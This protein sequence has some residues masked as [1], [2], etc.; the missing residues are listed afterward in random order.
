MVGHELTIEH[1]EPRALHA[2]DQPGER[3][4]ARILHAAEHALP[5]KHPVEGDSIEP[6][7]EALVPGLVGLPAFE[8]VRVAHTLERAIARFDAVA[9]PAFGEGF[10]RFGAGGDRGGEIPVAGD[11]ESILPDGLA[12]ALGNVE[13]VKREDRPFARLHPEHLGIVPVIGHWKQTGAV[14]GQQQFGRDY[15]RGGRRSW[16]I[17]CPST[18]TGWEPRQKHIAKDALAKL[19][20]AG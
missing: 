4:L 7:D 13:F 11:A 20:R 14:G 15:G 18:A 17:R 16:H 3:H 19:T 10:A 8:A 6:A 12:Q 1:V 2:G 5:A 9:D